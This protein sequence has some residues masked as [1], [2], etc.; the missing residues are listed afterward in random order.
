MSASQNSQLSIVPRRGES[1]LSVLVSEQSESERAPDHFQDG[2]AQDSSAGQGSLLPNLR[3]P[4]DLCHTASAGGV[5][6]EWVTQML[7]EGDA[8][9]FKKYS[10]VKLQM[11]RE[12]LEK[13]NRHANEMSAQKAGDQ[14][15]TVLVQ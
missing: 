14:K 10:Q 3:S 8:Q 2:L 4:L 5:A 15:R 7:R 9:A 12:A 11:T 13:L 6:D 1:V